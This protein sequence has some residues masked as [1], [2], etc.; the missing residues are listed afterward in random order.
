MRFER[1]YVSLVPIPDL[2][3][4]LT[5][6]RFGVGCCRWS[7]PFERQLSRKPTLKT[8]SSEATFGHEQTPIDDEMLVSQ[9]KNLIIQFLYKR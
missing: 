2:Y 7:T 1:Y 9:V 6:C 4:D 3:S 5:E 8:K